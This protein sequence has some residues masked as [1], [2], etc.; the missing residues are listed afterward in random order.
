[1]IGKKHKKGQ[2]EM[3]GFVLIVGLVLI[4]IVVFMVISLRQDAIGEETENVEIENML[5]V[6]LTYT[7]ECAVVFEP[8]YDTIE[9]LIKSCYNGEYCSNL[10]ESACEH[11]NSTLRDVMDDLLRSESMIN[12]YQF[13]VFYREGNGSVSSGMAESRLLRVEKGNCS[14]R[15]EGAA[16]PLVVDSGNVVARLRVCKDV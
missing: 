6:I 5:D 13:D 14:G 11:L 9:D 4:G 2:Q 15:L 3:V 7:T 16:I 12:S 10:G 1:M 8:Q